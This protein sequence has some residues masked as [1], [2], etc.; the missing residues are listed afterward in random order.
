M[1]MQ[2][3]VNLLSEGSTPF[4]NSVMFGLGLYAC[5]LYFDGYMLKIG[6]LFYV[7]LELIYILIIFWDNES[8]GYLPF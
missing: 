5:F 6:I 1:V 3:T 7:Y 2:K 4:I 8:N